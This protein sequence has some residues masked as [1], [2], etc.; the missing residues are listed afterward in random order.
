MTATEVTKRVKEI[1]ASQMGITTSLM[2]PTDTFAELQTDSLDTAELVMIF[3]DEYDIE[4]PDEEAVVMFTIQDVIKYICSMKGIPTMANANPNPWVNFTIVTGTSGK[5]YKV[6]QRADGSY[7]CECPAWKFQK[8]NR[9][10]CQHILQVRLRSSAPNKEE[11][12]TLVQYRALV[13]REDCPTC[14]KR[15]PQ[16]LDCYPHKDGWQ[17]KGMVQPQ[18]LSLHC[19]RCEY[20]W[21]LWKLGVARYQPTEPSNAKTQKEESVTR[22]ITFEDI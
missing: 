12:K 21:A 5:S 11:G 6:S 22:S 14:K 8:G 1:I 9:R 20:D 16:A 4:I 3:E 10:D 13:G 7:G 18:W 17:V 19:S 15:L 2:S